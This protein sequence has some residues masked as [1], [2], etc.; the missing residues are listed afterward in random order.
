MKSENTTE[1]RSCLC[2]AKNQRDDI[3]SQNA[4]MPFSPTSITGLN[5]VSGTDPACDLG[6]VILLLWAVS[7]SVN[8]A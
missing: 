8:W 6:S 4:W 2:S 7:S 1:L 3:G 5:Y